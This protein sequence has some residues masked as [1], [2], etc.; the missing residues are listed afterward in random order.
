VCSQCVVR[1]CRSWIRIFR[2]LFLACWWPSKAAAEYQPRNKFLATASSQER[3]LNLLMRFVKRHCGFVDCDPLEH[4]PT[5]YYV[6]VCL[7]VWTRTKNYL[8]EIDVCRCVMM[9]PTSFYILTLT[10]DLQSYFAILYFVIRKIAYN[11]KTIGHIMMHFYAIMY[12]VWFYQL[13]V[14][15]WPL[16]WWLCIGFYLSQIQFNCYECKRLLS[17]KHSVRAT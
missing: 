15:R 11:L 17:L 13:N 9:N 5:R 7:S 3:T 1:C 14:W 8:S 4:L 6:S 2:G 10:F 16:T 12:P